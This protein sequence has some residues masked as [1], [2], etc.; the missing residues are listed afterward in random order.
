MEK[1]A[2]E[3][4]ERGNLEG[5]KIFFPPGSVDKISVSSDFLSFMIIKNLTLTKVKRTV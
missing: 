1:T 2:A 4:S 3:K 5:K